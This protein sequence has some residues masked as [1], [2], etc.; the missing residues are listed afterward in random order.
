LQKLTTREPDDQQLEV[1]L[2]ALKAVIHNQNNLDQEI[3]S[4]TGVQSA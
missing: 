1:A 2:T 3:N 4:P